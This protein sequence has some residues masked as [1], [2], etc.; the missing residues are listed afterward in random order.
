MDDW[1]NFDRIPNDVYQQIVNSDEVAEIVG[2][3]PDS[4]RSNEELVAS[5][6]SQFGIDRDILNSI[7]NIEYKHKWSKTTSKDIYAELGLKRG[8]PKF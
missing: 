7:I 1:A 8:T 3:I 2:D 5:L 6:E 4:G